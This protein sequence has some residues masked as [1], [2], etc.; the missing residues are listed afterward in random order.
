MNMAEV[1]KL[2]AAS[3]SRE[4]RNNQLSKLRVI[5]SRICQEMGIE[6]MT[7]LERGSSY[8][9]RPSISK[10]DPRR[11]GKLTMSLQELAIEASHLS[12]NERQKLLEQV[13][14]ALGLAS[15]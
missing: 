13:R 14:V 1:A 9:V 5:M 2:A 4:D 12:L 10:D 6:K 15:K 3:K 7:V 11:R 8:V